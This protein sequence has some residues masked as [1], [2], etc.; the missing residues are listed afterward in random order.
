MARIARRASVDAHAGQRPGG[1]HP[2]APTRGAGA[3]F[4]CRPREQGEPYGMVDEPSRRTGG[5]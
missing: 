2:G 3:R 1:P 5:Q 4:V